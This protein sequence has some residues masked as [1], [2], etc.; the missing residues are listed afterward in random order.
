M[1]IA[2]G[3]HYPLHDHTHNLGFFKPFITLG[4]QNLYR[5]SSVNRIIMIFSFFYLCHICYLY[6][7]LHEFILTPL[8]WLFFTL[9]LP[10]SH[11]PSVLS[12]S[13]SYLLWWYRLREV[14][15]ACASSTMSQRVPFGEKPDSMFPAGSALLLCCLMSPANL[16]PHQ[17][18]SN[19][20]SHFPYTLSFCGTNSSLSLLGREIRK[21]QR[22]DSSGDSGEFL[23]H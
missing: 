8:L 18:L 9:P 19:S 6:F 10:T 22:S 13:S 21:L 14:P 3:R 5:K 17:S 12:R 1:S 2:L 4:E 20:L 16:N 15:Q 11:V 7:L 23:P